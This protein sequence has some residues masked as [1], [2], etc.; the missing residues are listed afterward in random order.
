MT[1]AGLAAAR[2]STA[3]LAEIVPQVDD[4]RWEPPSA[5]V[6]RRVIGVPAHLA[7][8]ATE[9]VDPPPPANPGATTAASP[10]T[11]P[12]PP[13]SSTAST[14]SDPGGRAGR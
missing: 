13:R 5:C 14:S 4:G 8:L 3:Q 11:R 12:T 6:G 2:S 10:A 1:R 7:A 9:A